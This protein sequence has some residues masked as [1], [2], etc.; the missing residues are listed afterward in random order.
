MTLLLVLCDRGV[1][2]MP[3]YVWLPW[4]SVTQSGGEHACLC[5]AAQ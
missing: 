1:G 2:N 3:V 4:G 5:M